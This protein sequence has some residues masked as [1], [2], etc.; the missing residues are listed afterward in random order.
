MSV[1]YKLVPG[2]EEKEKH[3]RKVQ[4]SEEIKV[5]NIGKDIFVSYEGKILHKIFKYGQFRHLPYC[6]QIYSISLWII[7]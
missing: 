5:K 6:V 4:K 2:K 7:F 3:M 1:F